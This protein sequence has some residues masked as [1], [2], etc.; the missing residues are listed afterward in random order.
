MAIS[1]LELRHIIESG[2]LPLQCRCSIDEMNNVSIELV[3]SA[4]GRNLAV[5]GLPIAQLNTSR[6]IANLIAELKGK[7]ASGPPVAG[8]R[9]A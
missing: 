6:A 2:F 9:T 1:P 4:S 5:G 3:D 7:I 8:Q